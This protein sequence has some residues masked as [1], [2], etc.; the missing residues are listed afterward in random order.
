[1]VYDSETWVVENAEE[2]VLLCAERASVRMMMSG[3]KLR[4]EE[5]Q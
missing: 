4:Q 1:M 3:V 5:Q 2:D